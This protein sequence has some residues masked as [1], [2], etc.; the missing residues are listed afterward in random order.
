MKKL[1]LLI[2]VLPSC[3][4]VTSLI[5]KQPIP[6]V[7]VSRIG[8]TPFNVAS[9][10]VSLAESQPTAV[11]GLYNAGQVVSVVENNSGK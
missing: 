7:P 10:D 1:L 8:G 11:W 9:A 2:L 5:T 3:A 4:S 6:T